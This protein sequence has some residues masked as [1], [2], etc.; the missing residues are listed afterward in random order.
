MEPVFWHALF[1]LNKL[2]LPR[3]F[4]FSQKVLCPQMFFKLNMRV[5]MYS[6]KSFYFPLLWS[7]FPLADIYFLHTL[8]DLVR[9]PPSPGPRRFGER[10]HQ[11][12]GP[13]RRPSLRFVSLPPSS[14]PLKRRFLNRLFSSVP[15]LKFQS[16]QI[17]FKFLL[18][19]KNWTMVSMRCETQLFYIVLM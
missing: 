19:L 15:K 2:F 10:A 5:F 9:N 13:H 11:W 1:W 18:S 14:R 7:I 8:A 16:P 6:P 3:L 17:Q 4:E 12:R